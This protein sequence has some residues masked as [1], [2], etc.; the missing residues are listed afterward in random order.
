MKT[1][2]RV[3]PK[4]R[5]ILTATN[6]RTNIATFFSREEGMKQLHMTYRNAEPDREYVL[7]TVKRYLLEERTGFNPDDVRVITHPDGRVE[8]EVLVNGPRYI[9]DF[10]SRD[11]AEKVRDALNA[12]Q[13]AGLSKTVKI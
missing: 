9:A 5:F 13:Q 6:P 7:M 8:E 11:D 10:C 3:D 2:Y 12:A 1:E 4:N